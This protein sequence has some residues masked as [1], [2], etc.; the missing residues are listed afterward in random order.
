M[1]LETTVQAESLAQFSKQ[2][3]E[4]KASSSP[5]SKHLQA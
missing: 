3:V 4:A 2:I 1:L 5:I